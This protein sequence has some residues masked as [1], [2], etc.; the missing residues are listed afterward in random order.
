LPIGT[1]LECQG[2]EFDTSP[3]YCKGQNGLAER[4]NRTIRERINTLLSDAKLPPSWW[5]ELLDTVVY[6]KLRA[7]A[8]ILQKKTP[9]EDLYGKPPKL[10]HLRRIG[11][12]A[13]VLIPKEH[14]GKLRPQS[15]ECRLLGYCEPNQYKLYEVHS[16]RTIFSRDVEYDERT[17]VAPLIDGETGN[18]LPETLLHHQYLLNQCCLHLTHRLRRLRL[19]HLLVI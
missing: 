17:P 14:R 3:P 15:S 4:T 19:L 9:Y 11:S 8:S 5:T 18:D 16:G 7:P 12:R 6:L 1:H 10:L 2:V 13:W